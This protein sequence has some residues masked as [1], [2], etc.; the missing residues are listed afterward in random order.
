MTLGLS[1]PRGPLAWADTI[2]LDHVLGVL[3]ALCASTARSATARRRRCAG[4]SRAGRLGRESGSGFF[5]YDV[6]T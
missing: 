1:H 5:E 6:Q 3:E 4:W 2:G